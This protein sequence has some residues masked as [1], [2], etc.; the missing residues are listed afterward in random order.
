M[1]ERTSNFSRILSCQK[2]ISENF[3]T[4]FISG[5]PFTFYSFPIYI[6]LF[7]LSHIFAF[8]FVHVACI[9][10]LWFILQQHLFIFFITTVISYNLLTSLLSLCSVYN[11]KFHVFNF[12]ILPPVSLTLQFIPYKLH[13]YFHY[14]S[15]YNMKFPLNQHIRHADL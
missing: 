14:G 6:L 9:P 10:S 12:E 15:V 8:D 3:T 4:S 5:F 1:S 13:P 2:L 11:M 7:F